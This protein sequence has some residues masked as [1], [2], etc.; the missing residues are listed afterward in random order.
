MR[1]RLL[2]IATAG[3]LFLNDAR[4][5]LAHGLGGRLDLPVPRW[6]FVY[7]AAVALVISFV[8][9]AVLWRSPRLEGRKE[10]DGHDG[11]LQ[12]LL[13][14]TI[15]E[16]TLRAV[17]LALFLLVVVAALGGVDEPTDNV[18]PVFVYVWLW[19]GLAFA[20]ALLGNLWATLSP[21]DTAAR[22]LAIGDEPRR[23][24]PKAWGKWPAALLLLGFTW[25]EL[26]AP[27]GAT[28]RTLGVAIAAY[29]L[30]TLTGMAVFGRGEWNRRGEAF[31]VLYD[32]LGR[33]APFARDGDGRVVRRP[34]LGGLPSLRP[35]PGLLAF[36]GVLLGSTTFDG[37]SRTSAWTSLV[38]GLGSVSGTLAGTA[39]LIAVTMLV[40]GA[41][42]L[43]M[44]SASL[45]SGER[46]HPLAVRFAHSLVPIA[47]AYMVAHY[48]SLLV[49]EG[50][51][52]LRLV[53]DP[54]GLGW[55]L[56]GTAGWSV[57][58]G[59][60]SVG[61]IWHVQVVAIVA[62]HIGG[63]VLAHDRAVASF[64]ARVAMRTQYALLAV[65]ILFTAIGLLLLSGG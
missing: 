31:A 40:T 23:A 38:G 54:F 55:N 15:V 48:F 4:P 46:W 12:S 52:G 26:V 49:L 7:G 13:S 6:L 3:V 5:A 58:L 20:C 22:L 25:L 1:R 32:L 59:L 18:A 60:L 44:A 27:F 35:E 33:L 42:S 45:V 14:S 63:V 37:V 17:G 19:V 41:F 51:L 56:L 28:P 24:Y 36:V 64:P 39:G 61:V 29:T 53:S 62:G 11:P 2:P 9:L 30:I 34:V 10:R 16:W 8:A 21:F 65:M 50:Q 47:F 43:A 57:N